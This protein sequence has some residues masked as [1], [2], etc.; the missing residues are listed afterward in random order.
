MQKVRATPE[1]QEL[2]NKGAFNAS[3]MTGDEFK[4]WLT[5]TEELHKGLM[6][7]AGFLAAN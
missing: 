5:K 1:W 7:E 6:A 4:A 2:M 3:F